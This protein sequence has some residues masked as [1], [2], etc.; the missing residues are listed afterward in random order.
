MCLHVGMITWTEVLLEVRTVVYPEPD[1]S[2]GFSLPHKCKEL[3]SNPL[4]EQ[5]MVVILDQ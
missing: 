2:D 3:N 1:V 4:D 5:H